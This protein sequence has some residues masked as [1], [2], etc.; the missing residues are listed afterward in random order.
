[1][2]DIEQRAHDLA[3]AYVANSYAA[4]GSEFKL[5]STG[6]FEFGNAYEQVYTWILKSLQE[7]G[8]F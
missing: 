3:V 8:H 2:T 7:K 4:R 1:M 5:D 6:P